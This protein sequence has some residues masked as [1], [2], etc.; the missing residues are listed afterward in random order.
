MPFPD[1]EFYAVR[2][3]CEGFRVENEQLREIIKVM[4]R[5]AGN[6]ASLLTR[7]SED[8]QHINDAEKL[9]EISGAADQGRAARDL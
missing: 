9:A 5:R 3:K 4:K 2:D 7:A 6:L 8:A 1:Q